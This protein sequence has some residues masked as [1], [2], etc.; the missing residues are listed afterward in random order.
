MKLDILKFTLWQ[1][2]RRVTISKLIVYGL[3]W[4]TYTKSV[5]GAFGPAMDW[6]SAEHC[7]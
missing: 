5:C 7:R 6:I 2:V 1:Y 3:G 4:K